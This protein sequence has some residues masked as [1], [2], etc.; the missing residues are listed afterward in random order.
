MLHVL[1][2]HA[3]YFLRGVKV[4]KKKRGASTGARVTHFVRRS[5]RPQLFRFFTRRFLRRNGTH[6]PSAGIFP[7][8]RAVGVALA[9]PTPQRKKS[10]NG[11]KQ[12]Q[13]GVKGVTARNNAKTQTHAKGEKLNQTF[14][15]KHKCA[16]ALP[17]VGTVRGAPPLVVGPGAAH[18][19]QKPKSLCPS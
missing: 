19:H 12:V 4:G 14:T 9:P 17:G 8:M 10:T 6:M 7:C 11:R 18:H 15:F 13:D 1:T 2:M 5:L 3:C 16:P